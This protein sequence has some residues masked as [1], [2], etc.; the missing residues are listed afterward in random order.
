MLG[1]SLMSGSTHSWNAA[2]EDVDMSRKQAGGIGGMLDRRNMWVILVIS[3]CLKV[4]LVPFD[5]IFNH[6]SG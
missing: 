3:S 1:N 6:L 4:C 5:A 2:R